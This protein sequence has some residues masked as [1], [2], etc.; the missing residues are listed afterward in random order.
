MSTQRQGPELKDQDLCGDDKGSRH[1][2]CGTSDDR[3]GIH[4]CAPTNMG[5]DQV[6]GRND[7]PSLKEQQTENLTVC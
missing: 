3:I 7:E 6:R 1:S 2:L 5:F 4:D